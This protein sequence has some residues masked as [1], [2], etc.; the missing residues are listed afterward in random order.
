MVTRPEN[1]ARSTPAENGARS[2]PGPYLLR[3]VLAIGDGEPA[4]QRQ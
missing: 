1:E 4:L 2:L 3:D